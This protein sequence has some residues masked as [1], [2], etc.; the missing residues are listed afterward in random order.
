MAAGDN[1]A[2]MLHRHLVGQRLTDREFAVRIG[3][4]QATVNR[5]RNGRQ[6]PDERQL[7]AIAGALG[8][9]DHDV[10]SAWQMSR[11]QMRAQRMSGAHLLDSI[12][13][14]L[15]QLRATVNELAQRV[16]QLERLGQPP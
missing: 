5:W 9:D 8:L 14:Q 4:N 15:D 13:S 10:Q 2:G 11:E 16:E 3:T 1:L 12:E 7:P 6:L